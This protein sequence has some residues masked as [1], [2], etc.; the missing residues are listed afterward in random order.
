M[1]CRSLMMLTVHGHC[2]FTGISGGRA[3]C[4]SQTASRCLLEVR[5]AR[6]FL[7]FVDIF[8][9]N[10]TIPEFH[11]NASRL[12]SVPCLPP[13]STA[14]IYRAPLTSPGFM[15]DETLKALFH[16]TMKSQKFGGDRFA[17]PAHRHPYLAA[18]EEITSSSSNSSK[19]CTKASSGSL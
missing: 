14:G 11:S 5:H 17:Q 13:N 1:L 19:S 8:H 12:I 6:F 16:A 2:Y 3:T 15:N 9:S 10:N 4:G 7:C 18:G